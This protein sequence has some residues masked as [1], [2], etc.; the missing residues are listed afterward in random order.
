MSDYILT[1]SQLNQYANGL[2]TSDPLLKS[3]SVS[4][5]IS[6][7]KHHSSGHLYFVLKDEAAVIRCVMFRQNAF[8]LDFSPE[9]GAQVVVDG[10]VRIYEKDGQFQLYA[11]HMTRQGAGDLYR[12]FIELKNKLDEK[13]MF[14]AA[15]KRPIPFLPRCIGV[16]TSPTGAAIHDIL[17]VIGRRF[18]TMNILFFPA[19]V[20]GDGAAATV[21]SG[22]KAMNASG[23]PDVIIIGRG[24]G[25]IEDLWAFNDEQ[26]AEAIYN[27]HI[28]I[29]SAVG[30]ETDFSISDFV[31][32][33][34]APTPSAAA[35]LCVPQ[36]DALYD[37]LA[38]S[39][40]KLTSAAENA[41]HGGRIHLR[42]AVNRSAVMRA[43]DAMRLRIDNAEDAVAGAA[44]TRIKESRTGID[45]YAD[46]LRSLDPSA[47]MRRGYA[48]V[49]DKDGRPVRFAAS[50]SLND[51]LLVEFAD[52]AADVTVN[53]TT[54]EKGEQ[55]G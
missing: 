39:R 1:V 7:F 10:S 31:A 26:L 2:M 24:G 12:R 4:G 28:P 40:Q 14:D 48:A 15:R 29:V 25:S 55:N 38:A 37:R 43:V 9:N 5:E 18:P 54:L 35:E 51:R 46:L 33:M 49:R 42:N 36:L 8:G 50:L 52:G 13:G 47:V 53:K 17:S 16:V 45:A 20:Q 30:H 23:E 6:N 34:R 21:V 19:K 41:V 44:E 11:S 27:S 3:L 22:I 32:D